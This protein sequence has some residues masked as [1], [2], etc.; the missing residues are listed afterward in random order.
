M[1]LVFYPNEIGSSKQQQKE[2]ENRLRKID[3]MNIDLIEACNW[4]VPRGI[5]VEL[6]DNQMKQ[7]WNNSCQKY[8]KENLT[9][10]PK[11]EDYLYNRDLL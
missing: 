11:I 8:K 3:S 1:V 5:A 9:S 4:D 10:C 2:N 7:T 6:C